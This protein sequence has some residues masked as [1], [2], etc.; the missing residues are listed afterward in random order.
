MTLNASMTDWLVPSTTESAR[1]TSTSAST[2]LLQP[3]PGRALASTATVPAMRL[4]MPAAMDR[5]LTAPVALQML[6]A[7]PAGRRRSRRQGPPPML[8]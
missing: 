2:N 8:S 4:Y 7:A 3:A 5:W 6:F 1:T